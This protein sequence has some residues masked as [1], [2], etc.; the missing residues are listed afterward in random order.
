MGTNTPDD[1]LHP[2]VKARIH[3]MVAELPPLTEE[4][5]DALADTIAAIRLGVTS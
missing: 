5:L 3:Q 1:Q 2:D 4:E